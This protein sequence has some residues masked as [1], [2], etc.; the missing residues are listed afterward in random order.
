MG[1]FVQSFTEEIK[2]RGWAMTYISKRH[3]VFIGFLI[4]ALLFVFMHMSNNGISI[5]TM[6]NIFIVG[7]L[8][9]ELFGNMIIFGFVD[10]LMQCGTLHK[11]IYLVLM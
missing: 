2:Y 1:F 9:T 8:F 6:I 10:L 5:I 4:S 7:L 3:S 11:V